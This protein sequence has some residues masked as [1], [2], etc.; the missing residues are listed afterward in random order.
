MVLKDL[1]EQHLAECNTGKNMADLAVRFAPQ[2]M[3][4]GEAMVVLEN[5]T[6]L[7]FEEPGDRSAAELA[8]DTLERLRNGALEDYLTCV[9]A[10]NLR[11]RY[12]PVQIPEHALELALQE[13]NDWEQA[14][15]RQALV[16]SYDRVYLLQ[17]EWDWQSTETLINLIV[18]NSM[19]ADE[20]DLS[21]IP[22][23]YQ[24]RGKDYEAPQVRCVIQNGRVIPM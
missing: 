1:L 14:P 2:L 12:F 19:A 9:E 17:E 7:C 23:A 10:E 21:A 11:G 18:E 16:D 8:A 22:S 6:C 5:G 4:E 13:L 15:M 3:R 24:N 20:L